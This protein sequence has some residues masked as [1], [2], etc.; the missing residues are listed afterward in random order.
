MARV[1][2]LR[3]ATGVQPNETRKPP[4]AAETRGVL[5]MPLTE[6]RDSSSRFLGTPPRNNPAGPELRNRPG[7]PGL[8]NPAD[9]PPRHP[10]SVLPHVLP[11]PE[12]IFSRQI[13]AGRPNATGLGV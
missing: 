8:R 12:S 13:R 6:T 1:I 5:Q 4:V 7:T 3:R 9:A 2:R 11:L 10:A